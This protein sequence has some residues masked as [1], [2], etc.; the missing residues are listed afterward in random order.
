LILEKVSSKT[1]CMAKKREKL[2]DQVRRTVED[3]G[4]SRYAICKELG[5]SQATMSRFM[6]GKGL[7]SME[8]LDA[9]ADLLDLNITLGRK[10][11][12]TKGS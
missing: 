10:P 6:N 12:P 4:L 9:L 7:L 2:S 5:L 8:Y 11:G 1:D 3:S